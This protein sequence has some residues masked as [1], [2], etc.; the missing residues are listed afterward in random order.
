MMIIR[1]T[2]PENITPLMS[3]TFTF[4]AVGHN[5]FMTECMRVPFK[6]TKD[7]SLE[8]VYLSPCTCIS[9][10]PVQTEAVNIILWRT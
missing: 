1:P 9:N 8:L 3:V 4:T 2:K 6:G 10:T 5:I 7:K